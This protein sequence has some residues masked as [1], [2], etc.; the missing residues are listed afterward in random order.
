VQLACWKSLILQNC[1]TA[2]SAATVPKNEYIQHKV[3]RNVDKVL[4]K[5]YEVISFFDF[6]HPTLTIV[7]WEHHVTSSIAVY[8]ECSVMLRTQIH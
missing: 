5:L 3:S 1:L 7:I 8:Q 2:I 6:G 4:V